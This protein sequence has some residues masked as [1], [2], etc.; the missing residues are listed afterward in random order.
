MSIRERREGI[1][2]ERERVV[3]ETCPSER[4]ERGLGRRERE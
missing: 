1:G 3:W 4:G 2:E